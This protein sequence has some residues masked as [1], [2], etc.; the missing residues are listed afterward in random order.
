[1]GELMKGIDTLVSEVSKEVQEARIDQ[2]REDERL[3]ALIKTVDKHE[4]SIQM[5]SDIAKENK[6]KLRLIGAAIVFF[7][8]ENIFSWVN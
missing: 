1:M 8:V 6:L 3:A 4:E 7:G 5:L 2:A